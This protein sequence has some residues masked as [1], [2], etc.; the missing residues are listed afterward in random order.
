MMTTVDR[1]VIVIHDTYEHFKGMPCRECR[2][3]ADRGIEPTTR[4]AA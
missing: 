4:K 3:N 1:T 2:N